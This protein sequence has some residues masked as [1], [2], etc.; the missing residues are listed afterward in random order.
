LQYGGSLTPSLPS[1]VDLSA[2]SDISLALFHWPALALTDP[3]SGEQTL[4]WGNKTLRFPDL[5]PA[6]PK[7]LPNDHSI[8][9]PHIDAEQW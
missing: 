7:H 3:S 2:T 1:G 4:G 6:S 9:T 5:Y 8:I